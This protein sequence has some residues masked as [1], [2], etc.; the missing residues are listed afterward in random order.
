MAVHAVIG[1]LLLFSLNILI[2]ERKE[3]LFSLKN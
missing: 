1:V 3:T 2:H